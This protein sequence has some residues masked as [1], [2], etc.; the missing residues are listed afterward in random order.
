[1]ITLIAEHPEEMLVTLADSLQQM[2]VTLGND[3]QETLVTPDRNTET[4][5]SITRISPTTTDLMKFL[6]KMIID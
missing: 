1:M 5:D 3:A 6:K 2:T 4:K